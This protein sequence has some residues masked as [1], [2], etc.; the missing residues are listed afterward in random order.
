MRRKKLR[1]LL[2]NRQLM[3]VDNSLR[4]NIVVKIAAGMVSLRRRPSLI[5]PNAAAVVM[6]AT[7]TVDMAAAVVPGVGGLHRIRPPFFL[8]LLRPGQRVGKE[9]R[10]AAVGLVLRGVGHGGVGGQLTGRVYD[11]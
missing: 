7:T 4:V 10:A 8:R 1:I 9:V 11:G 2:L 5:E 6:Y 3:I